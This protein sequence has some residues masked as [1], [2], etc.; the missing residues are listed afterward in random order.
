MARK[1]QNPN[2]DQTIEILRNH[3][4]EVTPFTGVAGGT[5]VAKYGAAAVLVPSPLARVKGDQ[6]EVGSAAYY[7]RPGAFIGGEIARLVDRGYQK[8]LATSHF[9]IPATAAMLQAI[10]LFGEELKQLCGGISLYN[11]SLGTTSDV[12]EYDRLQGREPAEPAAT[13]PWALTEGH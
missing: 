5:V 3:G 8:F 9:E 6:P 4:F 11:E 2:F 1:S 13:A 7:E 10:H 12:Y